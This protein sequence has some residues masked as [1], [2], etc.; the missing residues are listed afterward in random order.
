MALHLALGQ[1]VGLS[2]SQLAAVGTHAQNPAPFS[3]LELLVL[4]YAEQLTVAVTTDDSLDHDLRK[5]LTDR[6]LV[7][8]AVTVAIA[9]ATTRVCNALKI[10]HD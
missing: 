7:E 8:L 1:R 5:H 2:P 3:E 6:E 9:N 4:R 10:E